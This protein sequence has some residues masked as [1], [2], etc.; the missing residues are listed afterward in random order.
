MARFRCTLCKGEFVA[1]KPTCAK[2]GLDP[3]ANPRHSQYL[4]ELR[5][6]H[7]DPPSHVPGIG[8][9]VAACNP[10]LKV[11]ENHDEHAFTGVKKH[12]NCEKCQESEVFKAD[13][14]PP[15][16]LNVPLQPIE[17]L[18]NVPNYVPPSAPPSDE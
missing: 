3:A 15:A 12:V 7:F 6:V 8:L 16:P 17:T 1:D 10:K 4:L 18:R 14:P 2:C 9:N 11:G 5:T 13:G